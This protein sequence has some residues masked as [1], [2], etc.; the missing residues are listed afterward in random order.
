MHAFLIRVG[1]IDD[2]VNDAKFSQIGGISLA[3][4]VVNIVCIWISGIAMFALKEVAPVKSKSAFWTND[5]KVARAIKKGDKKI[6]LD[7]IK[8]GLE[9]ALAKEDQM[10]RGQETPQNDDVVENQ[11]KQQKNKTLKQLK[12]AI[13]KNYTNFNFGLT[14][15]PAFTAG[16]S[17][18]GEEI[19]V[20]DPAVENAIHDIVDPEPPSFET[21]SHMVSVEDLHRVSVEDI[22]ALLGL[23]DR[24]HVN[25]VYESGRSRDDDEEEGTGGATGFGLFSWR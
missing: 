4:T 21:S 14:T 15:A 20:A 6:D 9:D 10:L 18:P 22:S 13:R 7:V 5:I 17:G 3:L 19:F 16:S 12:K 25:E 11:K 2:N 1:A 24:H 8:M 23:A